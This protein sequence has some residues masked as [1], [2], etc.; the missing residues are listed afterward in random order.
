MTARATPHAISTN[1]GVGME[2]TTH[3]EIT[4]DPRIFTTEEERRRYRG[5]TA[6]ICFEMFANNVKFEGG[7]AGDSK[8]VKMTIE[9]TVLKFRILYKTGVFS[10]WYDVAEGVGHQWAHLVQVALWSLV[11]QESAK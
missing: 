4:P 5:Y 2:I 6:E 1:A 3:Y 9:P 10:A 8:D 11:S 7:Y